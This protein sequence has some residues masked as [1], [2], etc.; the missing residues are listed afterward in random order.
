MS[1]IQIEKEIVNW[2]G[3]SA[4]EVIVGESMTMEVEKLFAPMDFEGMGRNMPK[5]G[6]DI[7]VSFCLYAPPSHGSPIDNRLRH[8]LADVLIGIVRIFEKCYYFG[9]LCL[10]LDAIFRGLELPSL[11]DDIGCNL[12]NAGIEI[13]AIIQKK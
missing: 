10:V 8:E 3:T 13:T 5:A 4:Q 12:P 2:L 11:A 9:F 1:P 7:I 6:H